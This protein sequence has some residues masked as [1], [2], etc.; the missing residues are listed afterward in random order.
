MHHHACRFDHK[1]HVRLAYIYPCENETDTAYLKVRNSVQV[2]LVHNVVDADKYHETLTHAWIL[3]VKHLMTST[4]P[5]PSAADFISSSPSLLDTKIMLT[6]YSAAT[7]F[8]EEAR[9][10]FIK[11]DLY[12]IPSLGMT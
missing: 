1:A 8:S 12:A 11:P 3:A 2:F 7:L 5:T 10:V 9:R 4:R 6:H